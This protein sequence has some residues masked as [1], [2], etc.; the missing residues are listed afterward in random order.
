MNCRLNYYYSIND[1]PFVT[2]FIRFNV[3]NQPNVI[4]KENLAG[5]LIQSETVYCLY[6]KCQ[7]NCQ[8]KLSECRTDWKRQTKST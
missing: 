6:F 3:F 5:N 7:M 4:S 1:L 2:V 8:T